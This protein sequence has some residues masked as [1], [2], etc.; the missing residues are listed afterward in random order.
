MSSGA[1]IPDLLR[2]KITEL[3]QVNPE[4]H[5]KQIH[6]AIQEWIKKYHPNY[7]VPGGSAVIKAVR[8]ARKEKSPLEDPWSMG[9]AKRF[10]IPDDAGPDLL[11]LLKRSIIG[12]TKFTIRQAIWAARL[13]DVVW[14]TPAADRLKEL[15]NWSGR[16][17]I[18]ERVSESLGKPLDTSRLDSNLIF[19]AKDGSFQWT[20]WVL[21]DQLGAFPITRDVDRVD[22][23]AEKV[24]LEQALDLI[25]RGTDEDS[26]EVKEIRK[27]V[28]FYATGD[29]STVLDHDWED[30][31]ILLYRRMQTMDKWKE[32]DEEDR[33]HLAQLVAERPKELLK[34]IIDEMKN[35]PK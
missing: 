17:A 25:S 23:L 20:P 14:E 18:E 1:K 34:E 33:N 5:W 35:G 2:E 9:V 4:W 26:E 22:S 21:A 27:K 13:K 30:F 6:S 19:L 7:P 12:D 16:Y 10:N 3:A 15:R 11:A 24:G 29:S 8:D 28:R 31:S 32:A